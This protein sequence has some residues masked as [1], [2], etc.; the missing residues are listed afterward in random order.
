MLKSLF[1]NKILL[2]FLLY[3]VPV[4]VG[5]I[6]T[7]NAYQSVESKI[8]EQ[9]TERQ[10][11]YAKQAAK[12]IASFFDHLKSDLRFLAKDNDIIAINLDGKLKLEDYILNQNTE[13]NAVTRVDKDG[14]LIY[15]F[16]ENP[17]VIG[18]DLSHQ[19]HNA[20]I[21][22]THK[23]VVSEV[24]KAAQGYNAIA[25]SYPIF[26]NG[27]YDGC[28]ALLIPFDL[29]AGRYIKEIIIE[30]FQSAVV[31]SAK[32]TELFCGIQEH[33]GKHISETS[34]NNP[35]IIELANEMVKGK[36]GQKSYEINS[37]EYKG[38]EG[39]IR[40]VVYEPA[41]I[42]NTFWAIA[43][44]VKDDETLAI[45]DEFTLNLYII[46]IFS[47]SFFFII[48]IIHF[49]LAKRAA[50]KLRRSEEKY[51]IVTKQTGQII[52]DY[53]VTSGEIEWSGA[54]EDVI[55][56]SE[57][58]VRSVNIKEWEAFIHPD[59]LDSAL[60][61]L[62]NAHL[63]GENYKATY[64]FK[65]KNGAYIYVEDKGVYV[66]F[67]ENSSAR[68]LGTMSNIT[69]KKEAEFK[70]KHHKEELEKLVKKRTAELKLINEKLE[71]DI[72]RREATEAEL[73]VAKENAEKSEK[74]KSEFLAQ[75]SHEIRTPIS[76]ILNYTSLLKMQCEDVV[77]EDMQLSY[78][79]INNAGMR[80]TRT[81]D[82]I[83][84]MSEIESNS[85]NVKIEK[86]DLLDKV[87]SPLLAEFTNSAKYK[88]LDLKI[89][90]LSGIKPVL[91]ADYYTVSQIFANL[92]DN[93]IKY[94]DAGIIEMHLIYEDDAA[95]VE[96][97]DTGIG[98]SEEYIPN[99]FK[100]FSQEEQGY[101]RQYEGNGLGLALVKKYC[102][103]NNAEIEVESKK[104]EGSVFRI[105]FN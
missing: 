56:F 95:I 55:G 67:G 97:R 98:I 102:E 80:L 54:I 60:S 48:I 66:N 83:L 13:M 94:T 77:N 104:G 20:T 53:N 50:E 63:T 27:N 16:P 75:M 72:E 22:K 88:G 4:V 93:A 31:V 10:K 81:I 51:R 1:K 62:D 17:G 40:T 74:L 61:E 32:G 100:K 5:G 3:T 85:F 96:V 9:V 91:E 103:L 89:V 87:I 12:G 92:I 58:E 86:F 41:A 42:E 21:I 29:I 25:Y 79:S 15:T 38:L 37:G 84:N 26:K 69:D 52:Y 24:F 44:T 90:N 47:L 28:I 30:N 59:D 70:L 19:E 23:P 76:T 2:Y 43:V 7:Y 46:V 34:F 73:I 39:G 35:D 49:N 65:C 6:L 45:N 64:R 11:I 14:K 33:I 36:A 99:L 105:I 18:K 68:L 101:T 57:K 8:I 71:K 78:D 82:L